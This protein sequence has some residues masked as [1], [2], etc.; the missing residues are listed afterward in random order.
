MP[1]KKVIVIRHCDKPD[2]KD[3]DGKCIAD[4]YKRSY[5]LAGIKG[6]CDGE[7]AKTASCNNDC[8]SL[9]YYTTSYWSILLQGEKP[10]KLLAAV[11]NKYD[12]NKKCSKSNRCCLIL[13]PTSAFYKLKINENDEKYCDTQGTEI[14][15]YIKSNYSSNDIVIVAWEH[16]NIPALINEFG[17]KPKLQDWPD[18]ASNRFDLVFE[19]DFSSDPN[20]PTLSIYT[21]DLHPALPGDI[22]STDKKNQNIYDPFNYPKKNNSL[23]TIKQQKNKNKNNNNMTK[24]IMIILGIIL[25]ISLICIIIYFIR[26]NSKK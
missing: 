7:N 26:K 1:P 13:N 17:I 8:P 5:L 22:D 11:S 21:Q 19:I 15:E 10:T 9:N 4:G 23:R 12:N 6:P 24:I 3:D 16:K 2:D 18:S 14:A 25:F 20:K